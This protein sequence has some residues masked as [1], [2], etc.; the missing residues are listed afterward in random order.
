MNLPTKT[1]YQVSEETRIADLVVLH[2]TSD[3]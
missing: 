2:Q 3:H 1:V